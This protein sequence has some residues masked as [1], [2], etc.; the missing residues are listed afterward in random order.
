MSEKTKRI[1]FY[2]KG[3]IGK[4]TI[5]SNLSAVLASEGR[6]VLH[7]GCDPKADST[8]LLMGRRIP[9]VLEQQLEHQ[10]TIRR[11]DILFQSSCGVW[12]IEAG[13][14]RA[15]R[16]CAGIGI[17]TMADTL[18]CLGILK[19]D[20]DVILYDVLGD[21]VC[22]G[23][24]MPMRKHFV[25]K[26]Y[27]VTSPDFMSLYAANNIMRGVASFAYGG[28]RM[29]GLVLNHLKGVSEEEPVRRFSELTGA[30]ICARLEESVQIKAADYRQELLQERYPKTHVCR[31]LENLAAHIIAGRS[32]D[33]VRPLSELEMDEFRQEISK[34]GVELWE[35]L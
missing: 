3:G 7:I 15:G 1:A 4:S 14:P 34:I 5:A 26:V 18:D 11:E 12:C 9:T 23:F 35:R 10:G 27:I 2:G 28:V 22:G 32:M 29:G 25:D 16:G 17:T 19:E 31:V 6:K 24:A 13:G 20:W 30:E 8:R 33:A 21:V